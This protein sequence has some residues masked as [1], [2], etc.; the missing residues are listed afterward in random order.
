MTTTIA[1]HFESLGMPAVYAASREALF[2]QLEQR[3]APIL[4]GAPEVRRFTPGRIEIFGKHTDYAG[5]HS[6][7][8]AVP[9]GIAL[10]ASRRTDGIV[11]VGDIFRSEEH[12]SELQSR[13]HLVCR[14]LLEKKNNI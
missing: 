13:L 9:R 8:A 14:L 3:A 10:A 7:L 5:G 6:L 11:R 4:E 12:T 1:Q 2:A